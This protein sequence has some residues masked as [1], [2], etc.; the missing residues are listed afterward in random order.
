MIFEH[1]AGDQRD[2]QDLSPVH[3]GHRVQI[4]P[5]FVRMVEVFGEHR[6]WVEV[7]A[8]QIDR[9]HQTRGVANDRLLRRGARGVAQFGDLDPVRPLL[10]SPF[11]ENCLLLESFDETFQDH[12]TPSHSAKGTVGN[13]EVVPDQLELGAVGTVR[14]VLERRLC[15]GG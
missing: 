11:L 10:R 5:E 7:D 15:P 2:V 9:P 14:R 8:A 12:R 3:T 1:C 13:A 4:D 6:M